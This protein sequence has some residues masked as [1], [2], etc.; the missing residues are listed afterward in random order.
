[1]TRGGKLVLGLLAVGSALALAAATN[2]WFITVNSTSPI[3]LSSALVRYLPDTGRRSF[4]SLLTYG[5]LLSGSGV[6]P[7][8][9]PLVLPGDR[10][11][12][13]ATVGVNGNRTVR[14]SIA[15]EY[16]PGETADSV[17]RWEV[18]TYPRADGSSVELT[19][20]Q[21]DLMA[22]GTP[23][24]RWYDAA[25]QEITDPHPAAADYSAS[26][27]TDISS[28]SGTVQGN[29]AT[30]TTTAITTTYAPR[31]NA[32]LPTYRN[33][34]TTADTVIHE[35][36]TIV[37][38]AD[39][40]LWGAAPPARYLT[41]V[42]TVLFAGSSG[43]LPTRSYLLIKN[44][45][46][47]ET[48]TG[49]TSAPVPLSIGNLSTVNTRVRIGLTA[50]L[51]PHSGQ[52]SVLDLRGPDSDG[53]YY[54]GAS[55]EGKFVELLTFRPYVGSGYAWTKAAEA[56]TGKSPWALWD[57]TVNSS[58]DV[59]PVPDGQGQPVKYV[60]TDRLG[61]AS[62]RSGLSGS[63][64]DDAE[65]EHLFNALYCDDLPTITLRLSYYVRQSEFMD[66]VEFYSQDLN[67]DMGDYAG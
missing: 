24:S 9:T 58:F 46:A 22:R 8:G 19:R 28:V 26:T 49:D 57:L 38:A 12:S 1:M 40:A 64:D 43:G 13:S 29:P 54:L 63:A 20:K 31:L 6:D 3:D 65:Y 32:E 27:T 42:E 18:R 41:A 50:Y 36:P 35:G 7:D 56:E 34:I 55:S 17:I 16:D 30:I 10:L 44:V 25:D 21:R 60:V 4:S 52:P 51:T 11:L 2:A 48:P 67:M 14:T 23:A 62:E 15:R 5:N 33:V 47:G 45:G 61:V 66:W 59:P 53:V 39:S 37:P